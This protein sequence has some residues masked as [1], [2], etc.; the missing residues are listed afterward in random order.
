[1][2][3]FCIIGNLNGCRI[4]KTIRQSSYYLLDTITIDTFEII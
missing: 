3:F 2:N 1:M 4:T